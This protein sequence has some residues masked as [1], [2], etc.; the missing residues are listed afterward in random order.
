MK[1]GVGLPCYDHDFLVAV[2][3]AGSRFGFCGLPA[4]HHASW[5]GGPGRLLDHFARR[6]IM[7]SS[8]NGFRPI[9][10]RLKRR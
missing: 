4:H 7:S 2:K 3:A 9:G 6:R 10:C 1:Q 5:P 8:S